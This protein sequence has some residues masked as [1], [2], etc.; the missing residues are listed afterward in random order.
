[1]S[2]VDIIMLALILVGGV[3]GSFVGNWLG[4]IVGRWHNRRDERKERNK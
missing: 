2:S 3:L 4:V 1:M